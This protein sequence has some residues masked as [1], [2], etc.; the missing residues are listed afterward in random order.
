MSYFFNEMTEY[1]ERIQI[2]TTFFVPKEIQNAMKSGFLSYFLN[3]KRFLQNQHYE[4]DFFRYEILNNHVIQIEYGEVL[5]ELI[6]TSNLLIEYSVYRD[7]VYLVDIMIPDQDLGDEIEE[8]DIL[9][10]FLL[11]FSI[12]SLSQYLVNT[13]LRGR[14]IVAG[15]DKSVFRISKRRYSEGIMDKVEIRLNK[16]DKKTHFTKEILYIYIVVAPVDKYIAMEYIENYNRDNQK[17]HFWSY[18]IRE[19]MNCHHMMEVNTFLEM[20]LNDYADRNM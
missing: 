3:L 8:D 10:H 7:Q 4:T 11:P 1:D 20:L 14:I 2:A 6:P 5:F 13:L 9:L 15:D 12:F 17:E 18:D 16:I 19:S